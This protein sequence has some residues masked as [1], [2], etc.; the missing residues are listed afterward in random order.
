[1]FCLHRTQPSVFLEVVHVAWPRSKSY[2]SYK[3]SRADMFVLGQSRLSSLERFVVPDF[4]H[5][6]ALTR[7]GSNLPFVDGCRPEKAIAGLVT[8]N[9]IREDIIYCIH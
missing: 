7:H 8:Y 4:K 6:I 1:M 5:I 2:Q 3:S 9:V